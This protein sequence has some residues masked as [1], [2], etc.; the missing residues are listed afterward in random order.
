[1]L[2][3]F[4]ETPETY[5]N[6]KL[7]MDKLGLNALD[8]GRSADGKMQMIMVGKSGGKPTYNCPVGDGRAPF[9]EK[10]NLYTLGQI[11]QHHQNYVA[12][13][14]P[15]KK[16]AEY[17]NFVNEHLLSGDEDELVLSKL[18]PASLHSN[19][20]AVDKIIEHIERHGFETKEIGEAWMVQFLKDNNIV[21]KQKQGR[22]GLDGNQ[23]RIFTK[24]ADK[25]SQRIEEEGW[26]VFTKVQPCV[27]ALRALDKVI[28][29]C[30]GQDLKPSAHTSIKT[31][32]RLYRDIPGL[33]VTPKV[34]FID[35]HVLQFLDMEAPPGVGLGFY[36]EQATEASHFDF[37]VSRHFL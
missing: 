1:M 36:S 8:F 14:R 24:A 12:A 9:L 37:K 19:L 30:F 4:P 22:P 20:G 7:I 10:C 5:F 35:Q 21:R 32:L 11:A 6:V 29:D 34:H 2:A 26:D 33:S 18:Y 16:Q 25:L 27:V 23:A 17:Q 15:H 13:G 28:Q 3:C 31:F